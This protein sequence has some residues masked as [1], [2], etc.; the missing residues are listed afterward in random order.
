MP[1]RTLADLD[2][3]LAH[4]QRSPRDIGAIELLVVRPAVGERSVVDALEL[5]RVRGVLGDRWSTSKSRHTAD[6]SPHPD[7]QLTLMSTR[8]AAAIADRAQWPLAGDQIYVDYDL[9]QRELPIGTELVLGEALVAISTLPHLGCA[10]FT[11]R[12]GSDATKW[13]NGDVGKALRLRGVNARIVRGGIV[14]RG[15]VVRRA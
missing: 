5:D 12:F 3:C 8:A 15:D 1:M 11:E 13:V 14:R 10:K 9:S 6:G 2:A 7:Q 4:I